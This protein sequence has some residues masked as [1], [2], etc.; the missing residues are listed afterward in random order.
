LE[1]TGI[2]P[3]QSIDSIKSKEADKLINQINV[4]K[5]AIKSYF[6]NNDKDLISLA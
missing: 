1:F 3:R 6:K 4:Q 5:K 2:P